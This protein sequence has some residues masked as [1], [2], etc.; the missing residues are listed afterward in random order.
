MNAILDQAIQDWSETQLNREMDRTK[1]DLF[2]NRNAAFY[3]SLLC[4][5]NF[6]WDTSIPTAATD[7]I[8]LWW[9][10]KFFQKLTRRSR[11]TVLMHEIRHPAYLHMIRRGEREPRLWNIACDHKINLE[12]EEEG[13][14]FEGIEWAYKD[15]KY[16][17]P[18]IDAQGKSHKWVEEKIYDD[19][20]QQNFQP[21]P[22]YYC[23]MKPTT[24]ADR[25][26]IINTIV[27]A[28][29]QAKMAAG[30]IPGDI[31]QIVNKFLTPIVPWEQLL[32][33]FMQEL[34]EDGY[35]WSKPN[36]R[37]PDLYMP[38]RHVDEGKLSHLMYYEDTSGSIS[39]DDNIRF[40]S[41]FKYV[42]EQFRPEQMT[43][44]QFDCAIQQELVY[45]PDDPFDQ[46]KIMGRGGTDL[47]PVRE[48]MLKHRPTA[49]IIFSDLYCAPMEPLPFEIPVLWVCIRNRE[50]TV[51]FGRLIHIR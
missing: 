12:L 48:H 44:V 22:D 42:K 20:V 18:W 37:F 28:I 26:R 27:R 38:S 29:Q 34:V 33:R 50:A 7:G 13:Y 47:V 36:R 46:I 1:S 32:H 6:A 40:L 10:P 9:N 35:T 49:A 39:D 23:D 4:S 25:G 43:L 17:I 19:L 24:Q 5:L 3:G 31:E 16:R 14:S 45:G 8:G 30:N 15:P 2:S 51:P 11:E 41:E 21:P